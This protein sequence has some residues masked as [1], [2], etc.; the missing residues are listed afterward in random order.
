MNAEVFALAFT[1]ALNPK[2]LAGGHRSRQAPGRWSGRRRRTAG[3]SGS[4]PRPGSGWPCRPA[5]CA[6]S[7][8]QDWT[9]VPW[10]QP[11]GGDWRPVAGF[12]GRR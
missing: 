12:R 3:R 5:R 7:R 9:V 10:R 11:S 2:L 1:A 4:W 6:V 8:G